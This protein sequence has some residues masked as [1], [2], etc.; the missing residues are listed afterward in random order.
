MLFSTS[1]RVPFALPLHGAETA[2]A[3]SVQN[4]EH[5]RPIDTVDAIALPNLILLHVA[6]IRRALEQFGQRFVL[7]LFIAGEHGIEEVRQ[8]VDASAVY[9]IDYLGEEKCILAHRVVVLQ[10]HDHG[11]ARAVLP[12]AY[13]G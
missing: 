9:L 11:L 8:G 3:R 4:A 1:S 6:D 5:A 10:V 7:E 12:E 2:I 13:V